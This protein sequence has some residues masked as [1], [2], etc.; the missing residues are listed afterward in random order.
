MHHRMVNELGEGELERLLPV[1]QRQAREHTRLTDE[2][3][4]RDGVIY[5]AALRRFTFADEPL[6]TTEKE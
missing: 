1:I 5:D 2:Q 3:L 4:K 6:S